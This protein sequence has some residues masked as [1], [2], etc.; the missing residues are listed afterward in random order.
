MPEGPSIVILKEEAAGFA[1]KKVVSATGNA[2]ID[3]AR[4]TGKRLT[5]LRSWGKHFLI[6]F[7]G[8]SVRVHFL[9]FGS[10]RINERREMAPRLSLQFAAGELNF[11]NCSVR[12]I[13]GDLD[14]VYDWSAD[15]MSE[16]WDAAAA[17]RKLRL[18]PA[19]LVCDAVLDQ[20]IFSGAGNIFK[21]EVL[22]RIRMHPLSEVGALP[23][24]KLHQLVEQVRVYAFEFYAWKKA[25][26]LR[27]HW[28]A[29]TKSL[30]PRCQIKFKRAH[31]GRTHRRSFYCERCQKKYVR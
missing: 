18:Q 11:Y 13:E 24:H 10:Y 12:Y 26:V 3:M 23:A 25:Y 20:T 27:Q 2:K 8:F 6:V 14:A 16:H 4:M 1:G 31:L 30:C 7:A 17:R 19:M 21:N 15:V 22:F 29:H 9:L 28:L 5:A